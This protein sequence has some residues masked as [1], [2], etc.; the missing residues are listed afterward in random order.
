MHVHVVVGVLPQGYIHTINGYHGVIKY[1]YPFFRT[2]MTS[3][4][5]RQAKDKIH[6]RHGDEIKI[7]EADNESHLQIF[8]AYSPHHFNTP[9]AVYS[10]EEWISN[11][12][13]KAR[14]Q[15]RLV[16]PDQC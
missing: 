2:M 5:W 15:S 10:L 3:D 4:A 8:V 11:L 16:P 12:M 1:D 13:H 7:T 14:A 9:E 6:S